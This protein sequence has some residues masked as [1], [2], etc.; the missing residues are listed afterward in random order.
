VNIV[1]RLSTLVIAV[2]LLA[3][4]SFAQTP[5]VTLRYHWIKGDTLKYRM[6]LQTDMTLSGAP[7]GG[8]AF[9]Q[10]MTQ[11]IALSVEDVSADGTGTLKETVSAVR[12]EMNSPM[13]RRVYDSASPAQNSTDPMTAAMGK[14]I[15][16]LIGEPITVVIAADGAVQKVEGSSRIIDKIVAAAGQDPA[17]LAGAQAMKAV[18]SDEALRSMTEQT[19]PHFPARALNSGDTW[20]GHLTLGSAVTGKLAGTFVF[21]LKSVEASQATIGASVTLTLLNPPPSGANKMTMKIGASRGDGQIVFDTVKG[22]IQRSVM[23]ID[24]PMTVSLSGPDGMP[25]SMTN[26]TKTTV[27]LDL[28]GG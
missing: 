17:A 5:G 4:S 8:G 3:A 9:T 22:Q 21:T 24:V 7:G 25:M 19:F 2:G 26:D 10:T 13:G 1:K 20:S 16:A 11:Q 14:S 15:S 18:F 6:V 23:H 12:T 28:L 27:T